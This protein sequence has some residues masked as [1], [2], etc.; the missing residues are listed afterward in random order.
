MED[1]GTQVGPIPSAHDLKELESDKKF[2]RDSSQGP[3]KIK[4]HDMM[5]FYFLC[6]PAAAT[7]SASRHPF[8]SFCSQPVSYCL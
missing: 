2:T 3:R 7:T 4:L 5:K 6:S 1:K 8:R